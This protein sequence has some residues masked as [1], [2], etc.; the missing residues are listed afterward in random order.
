M[1]IDVRRADDQR[2]AHPVAGVGF[3]RQ[4]LLQREHTLL[5]E[6]NHRVRNNLAGLVGL[7]TFYESSMRAAPEAATV[8]S[9]IRGKILAMKEV[10]DIIAKAGGG[11][12]DLFDLCTRLTR[13]MLPDQRR[14]HLRLL[15]CDGLRVGPQ[16]AAALAIIVQELITN[17]LK[18]GAMHH[19]EGRID[20]PAAIRRTQ[21]RTRQ[22]AKRQLT[23]LRSFSTA[24]WVAA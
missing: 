16:Q 21:Q 3:H 2:A 10:H 6:L 7:V 23:W 1:V 8:A 5:R 20:L 9:M 12:I 18:H 15:P 17:S 11:S 14:A 4:R 13:A 19:D 24:T 22:L